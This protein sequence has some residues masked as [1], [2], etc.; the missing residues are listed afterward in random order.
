MNRTTSLVHDS[1]TKNFSRLNGYQPLDRYESMQISDPN[2]MGYRSA[3]ARQRQVFLKSY[4][5]ESRT[6]LRRRSRSLKL[7]KV[8][9]KVRLVVLSV[10]SFM[11]GNALKSC[12]SRSSICASSP[13]K[14]NKSC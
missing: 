14:L 9:G 13:V 2:D 1:I 7:K 6:K 12:N 8:V 4:R 3:R 10:V 11:R 5:L